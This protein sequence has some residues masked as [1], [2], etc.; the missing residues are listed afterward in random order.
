MLKSI[1]RLDALREVNLSY[2]LL[3]QNMIRDDLAEAMLRLGIGKDVAEVLAMI[4]PA[5]LMKLADSNIMLCRF[6]FDDHAILSTLTHH[7]K[8]IDMSRMQTALLLV[9]Q[10]VESIQ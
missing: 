3:A 6:R 4:T 7:A 2:L 5:Q 8:H 10:P 9:Q 1:E